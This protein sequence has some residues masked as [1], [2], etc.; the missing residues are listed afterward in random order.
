M[1]LP[2]RHPAVATA[3]AGALLCLAALFLILGGLLAG[4]FSFFQFTGLFYNTA[5]L[6][7]PL[8]L[9]PSGATALFAGWRR[10]DRAWHAVAA[11]AFFAAA[12]GFGMRFYA[13]H[14]E[15]G[16]LAV[17]QQT[18]PVE[19][20]REPLRLLHISD[21]QSARIGTYE[22]RAVRVMQS[23][24]PDLIVHTGDF[25][26]PVEPATYESEAPKLAELLASLEAPLGKLNVPG[27]TDGPLSE[28]LEQGFGGFR[29][30]SDEEHILQW[31]GTPIRLYG[32]SLHSS[33]NQQAAAARA[34][35]WL[36]DS[37]PGEVAILLGHAPDYILA[38]QENP[39]DLCLA[40]HTHG[41][42][43]R[44]PGIGPL[45]TLSAVPD[46]LAL[47]FHA[48]GETHLNVSGGIGSEGRPGL[49]PIRFGCPSEMTLI[50]LVP[51]DSH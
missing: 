30:L 47:G 44:L 2:T 41:G 34:G 45:L 21:I 4:F 32:L 16:R 35:A 1:R 43:V 15:P 6:W 49:P 27:D 38:V 20:L 22:K 29:T 7:I 24:K 19:G 28:K 12:S 37:G 10:D 40:G 51:A 11:L 25:L 48:V 18:L 13:T 17:R 8:I 23:L 3:C 42:Q 31:Q 39:I 26:Q 14:W 33:R 5:T 46:E 50:E 36:G 9:L